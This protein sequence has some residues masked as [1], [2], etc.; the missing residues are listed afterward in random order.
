MGNG[1]IHDAV[2]QFVGDGAIPEFRCLGIAVGIGIG[3]VAA[4]IAADVFF[5]EVEALI[6][7]LTVDL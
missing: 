6:E 2:D 3:A 7:G 1:G 5:I 4:G